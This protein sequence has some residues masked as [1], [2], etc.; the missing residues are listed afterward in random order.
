MVTVDFPHFHFL[1]S[2]T[3]ANVLYESSSS[4]RADALGYSR[5]LPHGRLGSWWCGRV[6]CPTLDDAHRTR[7]AKVGTPGLRWCEICGSHPFTKNAKEMGLPKGDAVG[8][9]KESGWECG[10]YRAGWIEDRG[11]MP[12]M[13]QSASAPVGAKRVPRKEGSAEVWLLSLDVRALPNQLSDTQTLSQK[14]AVYRADRIERCGMRHLR[15]GGSC[16][17]G[18]ARSRAVRRAAA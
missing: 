6:W 18:T 8:Q 4:P 7:I 2:R 12:G 16:G 1:I 9:R 15:S 5:G 13:R 3:H 17:R 11:A 10:I 14:I